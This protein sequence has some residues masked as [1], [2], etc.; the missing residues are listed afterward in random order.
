MIVYCWDID[1]YAFESKELPDGSPLPENGALAPFP[2][3]VGYQ[4][5]FL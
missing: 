4:Q 1:G 2:P 3:L 5:L